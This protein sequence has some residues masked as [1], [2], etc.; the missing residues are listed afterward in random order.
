MEQLLKKIYKNTFKKI[1]P[2]GGEVLEAFL[3]KELKD[4]S[5]VIDLGCG[6][7][8]PLGRIRDKL[9]PNL[10]SVGVDDFDP[11]L[12][13]S[14][15]QGIH[16]EYIKSNIFNITFPDNSF[17]CALLLDVIEHFEKEDFLK[18]LP[19]LE[20]IAK[21]II[22]LTPNGFVNQ[23]TYD[24]NEY[25]IHKSGWTVEDMEK[26]GFTCYGVSGLKTLRGEYAVSRIKPLVL[27][28]MICNMTEPLVYN[29][30]RKA[31]HLICLKHNS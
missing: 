27:G 14:K 1:F 30:P 18:F 3:I 26:L 24:G 19:Q 4:C 13:T 25:Q 11:Y 5:R 22:I 10:Y 31:Y 7:Y 12:E 21:K 17:D 8:S 16:S 20:K 6:Q 9:N 29:N 2:S 28:N 15:K 23:D